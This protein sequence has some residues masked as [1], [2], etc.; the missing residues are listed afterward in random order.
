MCSLLLHGDEELIGVWHIF[1]KF[2]N[3]MLF[4]FFFANPYEFSY[5]SVILSGSF[6]IKSAAKNYCIILFNIGF[7]P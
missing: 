5:D 6:S 7:F 4:G 2:F 3:Y 1:Y